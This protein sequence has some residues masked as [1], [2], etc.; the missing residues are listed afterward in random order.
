MSL[1]KV[2]KKLRSITGQPSYQTNPLKQNYSEN[3]K[4]VIQNSDIVEYSLGTNNLYQYSL[5]LE[6]AQP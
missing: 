6:E 3:I 2:L 4:R 1:L 5:S